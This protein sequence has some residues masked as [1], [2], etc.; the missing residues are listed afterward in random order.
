MNRI[1]VCLLGVMGVIGTVAV[2]AGG[3]V[4]SLLAIEPPASYDNVHVHRLSS[5]KHASEFLIFVKRGV[6]AHYHAFHSET[7][8]IL[9]G[10]GEMRIGD[11]VVGVESG[12]F[13]KIP[14]GTIHGLTVT[15]AEPMVALSVQAPEFKG[16]DRVFVE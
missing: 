11:Q 9:S 14:E 10:K 3:T 6:K 16:K 13:L 15:S 5:D 1:I 4:Q 8:Y 2:Q 12:S 7:V